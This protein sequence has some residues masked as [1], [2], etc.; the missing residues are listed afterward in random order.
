MALKL[1]EAQLR[2]LYRSPQ[3]PVWR[4][5]KRQGDAVLR[6]A[7]ILV[8]VDQGQLRSSI[9]LEMDTERGLPVARVGTNVKYA[10]WVHE[11]TGIYGPRKTPIRPVRARVLKW[12]VKNQSGQGRRRYR[13]GSTE[14]FAYAKQVK[15][16]RPRP[17]L[18]VA[19]ERTTGQS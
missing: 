11:G 10:I 16:V 14:N 9:K 3:G 2:A 12:P 1:D 8:P 7:Q 13:G 17:F 15:G 18:R 4:E 19:L 5:L 6:T